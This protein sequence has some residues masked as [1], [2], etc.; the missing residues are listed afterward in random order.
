MRTKGRIAMMLEVVMGQK[1]LSDPDPVF[2][3]Q[4]LVGDH[5]TALPHRGAGLEL[6]Q[7][8]L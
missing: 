3:K 4:L 5:E 2:G 6:G 1:N 7:A 8:E